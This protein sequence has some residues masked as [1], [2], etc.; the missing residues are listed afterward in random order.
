MP[1]VSI[2][3]P[4]YNA[5]KQLGKCLDSILHQSYTDWECLLIDDGSLDNSGN[6]C[7]NYT[8]KDNRFKYYKKM[9]GGPS[10]ARNMGLS[11]AIGDF[12]CFVDSDD[13]VDSFFLEH[14]LEPMLADPLIKMT[15]TG[16]KKIGDEKGQFPTIPYHTTIT[17]KSVFD[18]L[19]KGDIIKGWLCN[20]CFSKSIIDGYKLNESLH[21]CEDLELLLRITFSD[22]EFRVSFIESYDYY[23]HIENSGKSLSHNIRNKVKMIDVFADS[24]ASYPDS[25]PKRVRLLKG[26]LTQCRTLATLERLSENDLMII[27]K[28][29]RIFFKYWYDVFASFDMSKIVQ[30]LLILICFKLYRF[31][32]NR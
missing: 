22:P 9:N 2:V 27:K 16:L 11:N 14:L 1:K 15:V 13:Y 17:S 5:E 3:I 23:Y 21:Y 25:H 12:I 7:S 28:A 30:I 6:V 29:K 19:L 8:L 20:K 24:L 31:V 26:C 10:S 32:V 18:H 4:V